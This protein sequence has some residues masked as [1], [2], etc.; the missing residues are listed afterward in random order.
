VGGNVDALSYASQKTITN[1]KTSIFKKLGL[2]NTEEL[3]SIFG[4]SL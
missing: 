2:R 3:V 4:G 1:Q